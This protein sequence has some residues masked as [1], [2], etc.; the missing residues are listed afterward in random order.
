MMVLLLR[1]RKSEE[2]KRKASTEAYRFHYLKDEIL[3]Q[4]AHIVKIHDVKYYERAVWILM[5]Y[6]H[7]GDLNNFFKQ[8]A[9]LMRET[10]HKVEVMKQII[11][12]IAFLHSKNIVHRDVKPRNILVTS[13]WTEY[14]VIKLGDFGLSKILDPDSLTSAMSSNVGTLTFK[15]PEFWD[16]KPGDRVRYHRNVDVYAAGLTFTAMLQTPSGVLVPNVE[17]SLEH[18]ETLMP[19]GLAAY[20]RMVNK[21]PD[22]N[23]VE[24]RKTDSELV[25]KIKQLIRGI[26]EWRMCPQLNDYRLPR[27]NSKLHELVSNVKFRN[28]FKENCSF[29][30]NL[31]GAVLHE[32]L[33]TSQLFLHLVTSTTFIKAEVDSLFVFF[34][35]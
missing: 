8:Q 19:I 4:N 34:I 14:V 21:H 29:F 9:N 2:D 28:N 26:V 17:G 22:I 16:K 27:L 1:S 24:T 13:T 5:E 7:L 3:Q 32:E 35:P 33:F 10:D 31:R 25:V 15:A 20:S 30:L 6:C 18:S 11:K 12:R 23:I